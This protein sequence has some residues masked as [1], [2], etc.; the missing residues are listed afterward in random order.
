MKAVFIDESKSK[1]Y[2]LCAIFVNVEHVPSI[3]R[4]LNR[5][6]LK[7]QSRIHFVSESNRRRR[8]ILSVYRTLPI[9]VRFFETRG[10]PEAESR[11]KCFR[12]LAKALPSGDYCE[13]WIEADS[14]HVDLD[15]TVL[16]NALKAE[17][18]SSN[19][20]FSH[21]DPRTQILLWI[22]DALAWVMTRGGDWHKELRGFN[23]WSHRHRKS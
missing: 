2:V 11:E 4:D 17:A 10:E 9:E 6:R 19:V 15:K 14:N 13:V 1:A 21:S 8:Q 23:I 20:I 12:E 3:R 22:P 5:L 18:K 16:T 7:G